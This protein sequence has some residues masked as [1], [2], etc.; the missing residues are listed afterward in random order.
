MDKDDNNGRGQ[1]KSNNKGH[2]RNE[3][4]PMTIASKAILTLGPPPTSE[5]T[6]SIKLHDAMDNEVKERLD[7]W[8]D[9]N[10]GRILVDMLVK[11]ISICNKY[12]LYNAD[13][14]WQS[15]V[16][17]MG[18]ASTGKCEKEFDKMFNDINNWGASGVNKYKRLV[19][20]LCK[21]VFKK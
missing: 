17:G 21:K 19:Q 6:T 12:S 13:G 11:S 15:V 14:D 1:D 8:R 5:R 3:R 10:N 2:R 7:D 4:R 9:G 20:K 18:R 16:Q